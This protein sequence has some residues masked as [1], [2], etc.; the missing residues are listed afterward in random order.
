MRNG[1]MGAVLALGL[2][3]LLVAGCQSTRSTGSTGS[4]GL[5]TFTWP[6]NVLCDASAAARPVSGVLRGEQGE[7]E[8]VW[9]EGPRG[10]HISVVWPAGFTVAFTPAAEL[11]NETGAL[12]ARD[13]DPITLGQTN[14]DEATGSF[15]DPYVAHGL[16]VGKGCYPFITR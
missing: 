8:P 3:A 15:A 13:G 9:I 2:A 7:R 4:G 11:R 10:Q 14:L 1:K 5:R 16:S 6:T 12:I